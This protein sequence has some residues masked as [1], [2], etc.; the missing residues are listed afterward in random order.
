MKSS[1]NAFIDEIHQGIRG[2]NLIQNERAPDLLRL[3]A[4]NRLNQEAKD[5]STEQGGYRMRTRETFP[6]VLAVIKMSPSRF[7]PKA[8]TLGDRAFLER[9]NSELNRAGPTSHDMLPS[10]IVAIGTHCKPPEDG[11]LIQTR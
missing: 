5:K 6:H 10:T 4:G 7:V 9:S 3:C 8:T 2:A 1:F 11:S